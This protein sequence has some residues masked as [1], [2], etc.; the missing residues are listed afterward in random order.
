VLVKK[1]QG[2]AADTV[3]TVRLGGARKDG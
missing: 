2:A 1:P 3:T